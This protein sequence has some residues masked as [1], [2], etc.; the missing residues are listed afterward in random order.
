MIDW[1]KLQPLYERKAYRIVQ[2]NVKA[3]LGRIPYN[4]ATPNT[5]EM[6]IH[7]NIHI[8]DI[9]KMFV[10]IYSTIG[11][12]Y[13]NRINKELEK[14]KKAN[15]LFNEELLKEILLFLSNEGTGKITSVHN[16]LIEEVIN[17]VKVQLGANATV[18]DIQKAI[19]NVVS[20]SQTF[21]K[22][23]ALRIARTETTTSS[24]LAAMHTAQQSDLVMTKTW[25]SA[26]D[27]RTRPDHLG[28]NGQTV[29]FE[30]YFI[31]PSGVKMSF[32]GALFNDKGAVPA[33]EVINCRC[34][35]GFTPKRDAEGMLI[36]KR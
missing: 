27:N 10:E 8:E 26:V 4:N 33:N 17:A 14:V 3:I 15:V 28:A 1:Q 29:D 22:W 21:Y 9:K 20:K 16:T 30:D 35:I 25:I 24:G 34:T 19:Y 12:N 32:P 13:A 31:M 2:K 5:W 7:G 23:Q 18:I 36:L 11:I 6:L